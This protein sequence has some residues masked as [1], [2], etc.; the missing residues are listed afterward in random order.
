MVRRE[1]CVV[2]CV[3]GACSY[4]R[5]AGS[6]ARDEACRGAAVSLKGD[7]RA[8]SKQS[9]VHNEG[10]RGV[11][12]VLPL[13]CVVLWVGVCALRG[14]GNDKP[15]GLNPKRPNGQ[16]AAQKQMPNTPHTKVVGKVQKGNVV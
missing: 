15:P 9:E 12:C 16:V 8:P 1:V 5:G 3:C 13:L 14:R 11:V 7:R 4:G 6:D 10:K 2:L